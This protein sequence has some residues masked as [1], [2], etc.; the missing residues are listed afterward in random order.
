MPLYSTL[1][2]LEQD[3]RPVVGVV[4]LP[5][6]DELAAAAS[7]LGAR[8]NGRP[9]RVSRTPRLA[10]ATF[11]YTSARGF[12]HGSR[13]GIFESLLAT[14]H[15]QRGWPDAYGHVLVATG[16]ADLMLDPIMNVWDCAPLLPLVE[17]AGGSFTDWQNRPT[18]QGGD[19]ISTNGLLHEEL[20]HL[21]EACG[22]S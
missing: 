10:D 8:W 22:R 12:R 16:R 20:L 17:E 21:I 3:G 15:C 2:G 5:A 19:A 1:V 13:E 11:C 9:C 7:G 18:I 6:L 14:T 4:Y